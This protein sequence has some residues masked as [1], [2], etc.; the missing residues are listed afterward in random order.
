MKMCEKLIKE[1]KACVDDIEQEQMQLE[2][3]NFIESKCRNQTVE[4]N[5][6]L[7]KEMIADTA[8]SVQCCIRGKM[9]MSN[10]NA[11]LRDPIYYRCNPTP[12]HRVGSKYKVYLTYD[13]ACPFVT[14]ALRACEY[15]DRNDQYDRVLEDMQL[16]RVHVWNFSRLNFVYT[17]L[18][19]RK[20]FVDNG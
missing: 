13:F 16:R 14:H 20:W 7:W 4:E 3:K 18:N 11:S 10:A 5:L 17:F 1:G 9:D 8:R 6:K 15:H 19:K 2:R 12:H